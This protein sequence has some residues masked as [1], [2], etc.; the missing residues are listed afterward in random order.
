MGCPD[1][2]EPT[3]SQNLFNDGLCNECPWL[4]SSKSNR[5]KPN[6]TGGTPALPGPSAFTNWPKSLKRAGHGAAPKG[7]RHRDSEQ[8]NRRRGGVVLHDRRRDR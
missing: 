6:V 8:P 1:S 2:D 5:S 3:G 4:N 7:I